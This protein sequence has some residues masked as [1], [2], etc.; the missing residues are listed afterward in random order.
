MSASRR[1]LWCSRRRRPASR[2][3]HSA[4]P[5]ASRSRRSRSPSP[6]ASTPDGVGRS[7]SGDRRRRRR[8]T[9]CGKWRRTAPRKRSR[10]RRPTED[11]QVVEAG[12]ASCHCAEVLPGAVDLDTGPTQPIRVGLTFDAIEREVG[13]LAPDLVEKTENPGHAKAAR[14]LVRWIGDRGRTPA[15]EADRVC[16]HPASPLQCP[17]GTGGGALRPTWP[18]IPVG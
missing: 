15:L 16:D 10:D 2:R 3:S 4:W 7:G 12:P 6:A 11:D 5:A 9:A 1:W 17:T 13:D 18:G 14:R 8:G